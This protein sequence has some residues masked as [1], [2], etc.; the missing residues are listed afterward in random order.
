MPNRLGGREPARGLTRLRSLKR[1]GNVEVSGVRQ[2]KRDTGQPDGGMT[3][4][5]RLDLSSFNLC[6]KAPYVM[7]LCALRVS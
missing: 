4:E 7:G 3:A 5:A 1:L 6:R 2:Y